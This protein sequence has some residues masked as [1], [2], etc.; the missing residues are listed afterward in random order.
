MVD[1]KEV[2]AKAIEI[3]HHH[4]E[5]AAKF[6]CINLNPAWWQ[7]HDARVAPEGEAPKVSGSSPGRRVL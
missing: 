1:W 7:G 5:M 2:V 4:N 3:R 6:F